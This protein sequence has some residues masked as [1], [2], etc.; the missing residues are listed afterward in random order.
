MLTFRNVVAVGLLLF[1]ST[2]LW[3]TASFTGDTP[4]PEGALW[5]LETVLALLAVIGFTA[6]AWG[7]FKDLSWWEPVMAISGVVGLV[8]VIPFAIGISEL[9]GF[10]D[11]GVGINLTMHVLGS[12]AVLAIA[13]VPSAHDWVTRSL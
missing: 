7:V 8:A 12:G 5:T 1:G 2:F 4:P 6:A 11:L 13:F 3:M 10:S 9:G